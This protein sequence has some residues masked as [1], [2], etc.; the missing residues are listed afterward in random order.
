MIVLADS[1]NVSANSTFTMLYEHRGASPVSLVHP[2]L[3]YWMR[4]LLHPAR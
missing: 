1:P 4:S 2:G 3:H